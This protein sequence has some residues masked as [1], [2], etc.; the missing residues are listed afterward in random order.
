MPSLLCSLRPQR[1]LW[2]DS[3]AFK[4]P[5]VQ[6]HELGFELRPLLSALSTP[7]LAAGQYPQEAL[8]AGPL[9][10]ASISTSVLGV[11]WLLKMKCLDAENGLEIVKGLCWARTFS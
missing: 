3:G 10:E 5:P 4:S 2:K 6:A 1:P 11:L 9:A 7:S 8:S